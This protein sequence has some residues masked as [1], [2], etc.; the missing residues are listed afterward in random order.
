[1]GE[2]PQVAIATLAEPPRHEVFYRFRCWE[3]RVPEGFI[4]NFLGVVTRTSY[5]Q[6]NVALGEAYP[7]NRQVKTEYPPFD[8]EYFEWVDLLESVVTAKGQFTMIELGA[9]WGRWTAN[10]AAAL[11]YL[12][13][14]PRT[15]VAVE[16]EP[17]Y[18]E[19][20]V[21]HFADNRLTSAD[22]QPM[23][24][25][26]AGSD[27]KVGFQVGTANRFGNSIGGSYMVDSISLTTL[28]QPFTL[29]DLIDLDIQGAEVE[30]L[31]GA[32]NT[33]DEK[34]KKIH[35]GTHSRE[36]DEVLGSLFSRL[37]WRCL[38]CFPCNVTMET[39]WGAIYFQDGVQTWLNPAHCGDSKNDSEMLTEKLAICR[40]EGA[41]LWA[42]LKDVREKQSRSRVLEEGSLGWR[43]VERCSRLRE[44]T[45]PA[46]TRRRAVLDSIAR[47]L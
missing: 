45:A 23:R 22:F 9:G 29:V 1:M 21:Q 11:K 35:I 46:G 14:L 31:Q 19:M 4:V 15:F 38:H 37:G 30:V 6:P 28:L 13:D 10:A 24:A 43:I 17:S 39:D 5:W 33:L 7:S 18:F 41:R 32:A 40:A 8:E 16:A 27:G 2:A 20:L 44:K 42:E 26:V 25:A 36:I 34:V 3:G 47:K 12:G